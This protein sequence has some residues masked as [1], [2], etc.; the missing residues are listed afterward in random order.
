M[1]VK[2]LVEWQATNDFGDVY[3]KEATVEGPLEEAREAPRKFNGDVV[4]GS[5]KVSVLYDCPHCGKTTLGYRAQNMTV[6]A[7]CDNIID[8]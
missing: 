3:I 7:H 1:D 8:Y 4:P 2:Y 5:V 6:C